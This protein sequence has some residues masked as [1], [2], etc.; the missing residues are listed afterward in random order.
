MFATYVG[1]NELLFCN[2]D[3]NMNPHFFDSDSNYET[4]FF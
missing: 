4:I 1:G 3:D 2:M